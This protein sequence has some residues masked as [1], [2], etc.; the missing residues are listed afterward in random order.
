MAWLLYTSALQALTYSLEISPEVVGPLLMVL[1]VLTRR[2]E[3]VRAARAAASLRVVLRA[4]RAPSLEV[5]ARAA[6]LGVLANLAGDNAEEVPAI[7][8]AGELV[9]RVRRARQGE[10]RQAQGYTGKERFWEWLLVSGMGMCLRHLGR[11]AHC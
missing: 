1:E 2:P 4:L 6:G 10:E 11:C 3:G 5:T 7:L 9:N 8:E